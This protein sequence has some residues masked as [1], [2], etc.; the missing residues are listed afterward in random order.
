MIDGVVVPEERAVVSVRDRGFLYGDSVFETLRTYEGRPFALR[1]HLERLERS[2]ALVHIGLPV[3]VPEL[4]GE[5]EHAVR[6]SGNA[7]S[8]VRVMVTRGEGELG[9]D[10]GLA[11]RPLRVILVAP[12]HPPPLS[13]YEEGIGAAL[14]ATR[15]VADA[16][17][18]AGAKLG[19][20]LVSVLALRDAKAVGADE[21]LIVDGEGHIVEGATSNVFFAAGRRLVTPPVEAGILAGITRGLVLDVARDSGLDVHEECPLARDVS[22]WDE[23][24]ISSSIRE[25]LAVVRVDGRPVG[26]GRPGPVFRGLLERLRERVRQAPL[27]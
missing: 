1:T 23:V 3:S 24:M 7:E 14:I 6:A 17:P 21:A 4:A 26:S 5:V 19:N 11:R 15:R 22:S 13:A 18:A 25:M 16:T 10:P 12:L 9:L 27:P 2:A 20:Y 8:Y